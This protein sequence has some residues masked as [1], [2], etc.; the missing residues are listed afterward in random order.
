METFKR[1]LKKILL[2]VPAT[3]VVSN[4]IWGNAAVADFGIAEVPAALLAYGLPVLA[5]SIYVGATEG[6]PD[7]F[8]R[9]PQDIP[10]AKTMLDHVNSLEF[11]FAVFD[12]APCAQLQDIRNFALGKLK[13]KEK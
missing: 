4:G 2:S 5:G 13:S 11:N 7:L 8:K 6:L 10:L 1:I 3:Y 12:D 9:K